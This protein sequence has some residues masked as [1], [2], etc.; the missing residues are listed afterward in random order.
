MAAAIYTGCAHRSRAPSLLGDHGR[1]P[2]LQIEWRQTVSGWQAR[3]VRPVLEIG[4]GVVVEDW[5]PPETLEPWIG[6]ERRPVPSAGA[7]SSA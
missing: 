1:L 7:S 2:G 6:V 4:F 5:V 3:V